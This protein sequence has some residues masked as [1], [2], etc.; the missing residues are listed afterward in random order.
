MSLHH[1]I[2]TLVVMVLFGS[3]YPIGK[4]G[5]NNEL[6]PLIFSLLRIAPMFIILL[7]FLKFSSIFK[8]NFKFVLCYGVLMGLGLYPSMY[9]SLEYTQSTSSIILI[10]QLSIPLG[11]IL[12]SIFLSEKVSK[13]RWSLIGMIIVGLTFV[14][15]DPIVF[16]SLVSIILGILAAVSYGLASMISRKISNFGSLEVNSWMAIISLPIMIFLVFIFESEELKIIFKHSW[17]VYLPALYSGI[18][19]SCIAQV[20]MLWLYKHYDVQ[21]VIPF[22]S[23]FPIFGIILTILLLGEKISY[24]IITG[25]I[26]VISGNF[27]LQKIK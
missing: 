7:P 15:F 2:I 22:Y 17:D 27:F 1:L 6:S 25:S 10:M 5:L 8:K 23:L 12:G 9:L 11:V 13:L 16:K 20:L 18:I 3:S 4:I 21:T 24:L 19:V 14:C 26:I